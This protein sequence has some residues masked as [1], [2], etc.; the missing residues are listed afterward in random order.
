VNKRKGI[1]MTEIVKE[2]PKEFGF[3]AGLCIVIGAIGLL[4]NIVILFLSISPGSSSNFK[5]IAP[6]LLRSA[7][8]LARDFGNI[9]G[10]IKV[11][12]HLNWARQLI[13]LCASLSLI[14]LVYNTIS[15]ASS[16][17][18]H[19]SPISLSYFL[20]PLFIESSIIYYFSRQ[21]VRDFVKNSVA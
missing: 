17:A 8:H 2:Q 1:E 19:V 15:S 14:E 11:K 16:R 12:R 20:V 7:F 3:F 6:V 5:A 10:G 21:T 9:F 4:V 13:V 18:L